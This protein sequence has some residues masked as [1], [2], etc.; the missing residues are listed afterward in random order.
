M[1]SKSS[2]KQKNDELKK[3]GEDA[4]K[5]TSSSSSFFSYSSA[6]V[7]V[8]NELIVSNSNINPEKEYE[9]LGFLGEGTL[10]T[11]Y[12]VKN[13]YTESECAMKVI[14]RSMSND[15]DKE[16]EL[17]N[18]INILRT[19]DHPNILKIL[20]F[21]STNNNYCIITELCPGGELFQ[22]I[23]DAGPFNETYSA[24]VMYQLLS[25]V[26]YC[27]KMKIIHRDIKPENILIVG[28]NQ[29]G[30]PRIK[31]CDFSLSKLCSLRGSMI[32]KKIVGAAY[33]IAPEVLRKKYNE[34]C[35]LWSC[36]VI[37]YILLS[38]RPPFDGENDKEIIANVTSGEFDLN[39]PPFNTISKNAK[40]LIKKL[41]NVNVEKRITAEEAL[42]HLWFK[43]LKTQEL[44]N[45][46]NDKEVMRKLIE[47]LKKY[48]RTSVVQETALAYLV[49]HFHQNK[50]I[51][52]SCKLFN[53]IDKSG[54][55]KITKEELF[56]GLSE[57]YKSETL[58]N[59]VEQIYNNLDMDNNGY[60][61]YEEF[62][63]AAVSKEYFV[64][65]NVLR[66][67]FRYFDKDGSGEIT[68]DEIKQLFSQS[69]PD[70][71]KL[72]ETLR[73]IISEVDDNNDGIISY[74][75]FCIIMKKMIH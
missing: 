47:N 23:V 60:I 14:K 50:D 1:G 33:Y 35:D 22:Q 45:K 59:D 64:K 34:K 24:Y 56:M 19:M 21:F 73:K 72:D 53:Q 17:Y 49:H 28:K 37:M 48:K 13:I 27:H 42:N 70:K 52:N 44:Y 67:A 31:L 5:K 41:L 74:K 4:N 66:Y 3:I 40:D 39:N 58:R 55:G 69:I 15:L 38:G 8:S 29:E 16:K 61:G 12:K 25:A 9:Q 63:R 20:E 32:Q 75:E 57:R 68:F 7:N 36:G 46:I 30:L 26:N 11:V 62:V 71:N 10:A 51:I 18:E 65:D 2:K 43:G 54:D 6:N